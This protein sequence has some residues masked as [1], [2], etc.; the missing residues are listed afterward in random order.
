MFKT[1]IVDD[2][3]YV[4]AL[5]QKLIDWAKY[6]MEVVA[7]AS[8]GISALEL[9]REIQPDLVIVDVRMPGYDGISFMDKVREFNTNV[10]FIVISGH[11]QFDYAKGAMRNN[12]EDYLLKPINKAEMETVLTHVQKKLMQE[13]KVN[14]SIETMEQELNQSKKKIKE[15]LFKEM[16][17]RNFDAFRVELEDINRQYMTSFQP[18]TFRILAL[19]LD[20]A[21]AQ[22]IEE[23]LE[24]LGL[25]F[26][27]EIMPVCHEV[28]YAK[29]GNGLFVIVNYSGDRE[30]EF[31][32][33]C[34]KVVKNSNER[35]EKFH[36]MYVTICLGTKQS[37]IRNMEDSALAL[38][39]CIYARTAMGT[40]KVLHAS[41]IK[42]KEEC[43]SQILGIGETKF[44]AALKELDTE[45]VKRTVREMF[46]LAYYKCDE[47][48]LI[49]FKLFTELLQHA[50][51]YLNNVGLYDGTYEELKEQ[52]QKNYMHANN[53]RENGEVLY[54]GIIHIMNEG[55]ITG[56]SKDSPVIRIVK[57]YIAEHYQE[58]VTLTAAA[59]LVNLSPVYLSRL[60]KKEENTNFLDYVNQY[61]IDI[62]KKLLKDVHYNV[63][64][65]TELAGFNNARYFAKY[66]K[67]SVGITPSEYRK[68]QIGKES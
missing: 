39:R 62:A 30:Q 61:R 51:V 64:E 36:D 60:F 57:R 7:T 6:D 44:D 8:D 40:G 59:E 23:L 49:F 50:Y 31:E 5:M 15:S 24:M 58:E 45:D 2:E 68:R 41:D 3:I 55:L 22:R 54:E 53:Y 11:K 13:R 4:I 1:I 19:L 67:K 14:S 9:V 29:Y 35:V 37:T 43:L 33:A 46:T 34:F 56:T 66:F 26:L 25:E 38:E 52:F 10:K 16:L 20:N 21:N 32:N 17:N 28:A 27:R 18:G 63:A 47:D 48:S 65:V 12:V 42:E